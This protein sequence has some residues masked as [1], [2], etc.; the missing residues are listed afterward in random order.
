MIVTSVA[1]PRSKNSH[2]KIVR[3]IREALEV[4]SALE[5]LVVRVFAFAGLVYLLLRAIRYAALILYHSRQL[6]VCLDNSD[7]RPG[8]A[9]PVANFV[10]WGTSRMSWTP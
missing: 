7:L 9:E 5:V 1:N 4:L 8:V 3:A 6:F 2:I 10:S